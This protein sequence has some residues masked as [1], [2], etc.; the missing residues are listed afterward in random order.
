MIKVLIN[1]QWESVPKENLQLGAETFAF[2][3]GLY[4]TFRTLK[5][6]HVFL[7][8][9]LNRLFKSAEIT[10]LNIRYTQSEIRKMVAFVIT[11]FSD[12]NQRVRILAIPEKLIIYTS[13][14]DLD[15]SIYEG[16]SAITLEGIRESPDVKTTN[17]KVCLDAWHQ[18][19]KMGCF[20]AILMDSN[21][22]LFEGSRSNIFWII[23]EK[24][25]TRKGNVLPGI[26]RQTIINRSPFPVEFG[27][28]QNNAISKIDECFLTNSGSGIIP[29]THL[30]GKNIGNGFVGEITSQLLSHYNEW[31]L[32]DITG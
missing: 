30:N 1:N 10:G 25:F 19:E 27:I 6:R 23:N 11:D 2:D 26:T 22:I 21:G 16:V 28:L 32:Q 20:E 4:E 31:M 29:V 5:H 7:E 13:S 3:T 12:Q 8:P 24:V 18:A 9:H 14:L 17:Y 15:H